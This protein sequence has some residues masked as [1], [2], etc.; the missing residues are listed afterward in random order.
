[1]FDQAI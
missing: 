1:L